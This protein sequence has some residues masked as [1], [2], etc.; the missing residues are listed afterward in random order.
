MKFN[1]LYNEENIANG[2]NLFPDKSFFDFEGLVS[3]HLNEYGDDRVFDVQRF[4]IHNFNNEQKENYF[5][6]ICPMD[7]C[8]DELCSHNL[9]IPSETIDIIKNNSNIYI[10][11]CTE[12][13][14]I[15]KNDL[16]TLSNFCKQEGLENKVICMSNNAL[17]D[18]VEGIKCNYKINFLDY[19]SNYIFRQ[20]VIGGIRK[21]KDGKLFMC[22]NRGGKEHRIS[23]IYKLI[24]KGYM[25]DVN[26]SFIPEYSWHYSN[27]LEDLQDAYSLVLKKDEVE[28][29]FAKIKKIYETRKVD[30]YE[31]DY[32]VIGD[33]NSFQNSH[34]QS[35]GIF[36]VPEIPI[37]F[38]SSYINIVTESFY[39]G[40]ENVIHVTEKTFR[41]FIYY[42]IPIIVA[43]P[44]HIKY[45]RDVYGFDMFDDLVN[46]SYDS[47]LDDRK[48]IK[49]IIDEI[50]RLRD[51]KEKVK[52]FYKNNID[53]FKNN[54]NIFFEVSKNLKEKDIQFFKK[55]IND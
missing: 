35:K 48:R 6:C 33:D 18:D 34:I 50:G 25:E 52:S 15:R 4:H 47:E 11:I 39:N 45:L 2:K 55:I 27:S 44:N 23:L 5:Y 10:L 1:L 21:N 42:Q 40:N 26:Y 8:I 14:P 22:R 53:R 17:S 12:H 37:S 24:T 46:H 36:R 9:T 30:D 16:D 49:M 29:N 19:S 7:M 54:R 3:T 20:L 28:Y 38:H 13:E 51:K 43:T 41:P 32:N 31:I